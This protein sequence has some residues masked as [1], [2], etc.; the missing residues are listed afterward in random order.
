VKKLILSLFLSFSLGWAVLTTSSLS[1]AQ[2]VAPVNTPLD[3]G[4]VNVCATSAPFPAAGCST[5]GTAQFNVTAGGNLSV[6][7]V[8]TLGVPDQDFQLA[9]TTCTGKVA[10]GSSCV[11]TVTFAPKFSGVRSGAVQI[12]DDSG[13][14]LATLPVQGRGIGPQLDF[15]SAQPLA[16]ASSP[17]RLTAQGIAVNATGDIFYATD[18]PA[19]VYRIP[20]AGGPPV[21]VTTL[22][23]PPS[24]LALDGAGNLYTANGVNGSQVFEVPRGCGDP[25][26]QIVIDGGFQ[27]PADVAVDSAGNLY[28]ADEFDHRIVEMPFGCV[29][30]SCAVPIG[31]GWNYPSRL[32][33]DHAGNLFV[34]DAYGGTEEVNIASG[35]KTDIVAVA[36][37]TAQG[38]AVDAAGDLYLTLL[39]PL[40]VGYPALILEYPAAGAYAITLAKVDSQPSFLALDGSGNLFMTNS[41]S[42]SAV[43]ELPRVHVPTYT[44]ATTSSAD[45]PQGFPLRNTGNAN[46]SL[47][48]LTPDPLNNFVQVSEPGIG[49]DCVAGF[50]LPPAATCDL[51]VGFTP[52]STGFVTFTGTVLNNTGNT[53]STE[54]LPLAGIGGA[55]GAAISFPLGFGTVIAS[56]SGLTLN[57]DAAPAGDALQ[58][59]DGG[60]Y[61]AGSAFFSTPIG[62]AF[63]QTS[64]DFRLTGTNTQRPDADGMAFVLQNEGPNALGTPGGG[65]GYGLASL[66]EGGTPITKS[67]AVKF[68][69][70]DNDG[71]GASS[72]GFYVN[73][74]PPTVP[75]IDLLPSG[76]DLHS[77]HVF[78]VVVVYDGSALQLSITDRMT[79]AR[80]ST[81]FPAN[82]AGLLGGSTAYVGFTG[83]TGQES[84]VQSILNWQLTSSN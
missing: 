71:E 26:C 6:P 44:F 18:N 51:N 31:Q 20:A 45:F 27:Y 29:T 61:E 67:V 78:H 15:D 79:K 80:F 24:G 65:L 22:S 7:S 60:P 77:G 41:A 58:L 50:V 21:V 42:Y 30:S 53:P 57:G 70:Y 75:A 52:V 35:Q 68:D 14:V 62:T 1:Q 9:S 43:F 16:L 83:G 17:V 13:K 46:L 63:F 36:R 73:G 64:F 48:K 32:A 2:T 59:T 3:L 10:A 38:M 34:A 72:T 66:T 82:L 49:P 5:I 25:S 56:D 69:L 28:V 39:D 40:G 11:V 81:S 84:A 12:L 37:Y 47:L 33:L 54:N 74:A 19:A 8:L 4:S 76:I 23:I 55:P